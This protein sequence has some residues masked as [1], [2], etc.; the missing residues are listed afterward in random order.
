M[1]LWGSQKAF[2]STLDFDT[3]LGLK[4]FG[5]EHVGDSEKKKKK[6]KKNY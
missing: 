4:W 1:K 3:N 6:K 2:V 5:F